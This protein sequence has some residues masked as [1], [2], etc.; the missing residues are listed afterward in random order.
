MS[1]AHSPSFLHSTCLSSQFFTQ[2][3][4]KKIILKKNKIADV[5]HIDDFNCLFLMIEKRV[6][7]IEMKIVIT[8]FFIYKITASC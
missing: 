1:A 3:K 7:C 4:N 6:E 5:M 8:F 2:I